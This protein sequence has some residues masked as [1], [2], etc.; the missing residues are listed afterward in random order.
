MEPETWIINESFDASSYFSYAVNFTSNGQRFTRIALTFFFADTQLGY[1]PLDG[2]SVLFV[3][4]LEDG[5]ARWRNKKYRIVVFDEPVT[6]NLLTWLQ[7]NAIKK[8]GPEMI[9]EGQVLPP[10]KIEGSINPRV[11]GGSSAHLQDNVNITP[12]TI[13]QDVTPDA[14]YDGFKKAH[15]YAIQNGTA[16]TPVATKSHVVDHAITITP[17]VTNQAGYIQS[18][19]ID[20]TPVTVDASEV[21]YGEETKT[22]NGTYDVTNLA[23][24]VV[25]VPSSSYGGIYGVEWDGTSNTSWTRTDDAVDFDNPVPYFSGMASGYGS[26]FDNI[27]PWAGMQIVEDTEAGTLVSV[28]KF[29]YKLTG[30]DGS[31]LKIQIANHYV[32]G[33]S[34]SP[35]HMDRGDGKGER[36]IAFIGRY[37]CGSNYKSATGVTP[38]VSIIRS[39]ARSGIHALGNNV[40]Q[41]DFAMRFTIWLLYLVEYADWGSQ[42]V[43]GAG[44]G[45]NTATANMGYT[46]SM[47]YHTGTNLSNSHDFGYG[48][49]YRYIEGLWDNCY[50]WLDG[51]YMTYSGLNLIKKPA[52]FSDSSGGELVGS[53]VAGTPKIMSIS[54]TGG[55]PIFYSTRSGGTTETQSS[56]TLTGKGQYVPDTWG[57]YPSDTVLCAG[58]FY[59]HSSSNGLFCIYSDYNISDV[60]I[61]SRLQKLP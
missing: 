32:S 7:A 15:V 6:G 2:E 25:A 10:K 11:G 52:N 58:G 21:A 9:L 26:P 16:G 35:M 3:W 14:G 37:H 43:I 23:S 12:L 54:E 22:M 20:G 36:G 1:S 48:T 61:G 28:P 55:Y 59:R 47:P 57:V 19:E 29:W 50:D 49:Q 31:P 45:N 24:L 56:G 46:D 4:T 18:A 17:S 39:A 27:M 5:V 42:W 33:Y 41:G 53:I 60:M 44:C 30:G 34:V 40:W 13:A 8:E 51:C 38:K